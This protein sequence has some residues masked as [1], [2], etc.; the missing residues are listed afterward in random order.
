[1]CS[2]LQVI[3]R[4]VQTCLGSVE[5]LSVKCQ[6]LA[7]ADEV[8][9][10]EGRLEG[11]RETCENLEG[12]VAEKQEAFED[13]LCTWQA[14]QGEIDSCFRNLAMIEKS[15]EFQ[16]LDEATYEEQLQTHQVRIVLPGLDCVTRSGMRYQGE[17]ALPVWGCVTRLGFRYQFLGEPQ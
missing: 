11:L 5:D 8:K 2:S 9:V 12:V 15:L 7:D 17:I 6:E 10:L 1:M 13:L 14:F 3:G 4:E 16:V